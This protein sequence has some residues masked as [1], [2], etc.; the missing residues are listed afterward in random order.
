VSALEPVL[1]QRGGEWIGWPGL[2][3]RKRETIPSAKDEPY[4]VEAVPLTE[5]EANRYYHGFSNRTLWPLFHSLPARAVFDRRDW[6]AYEKVN[7]RFAQIAIGAARD[8]GLVW[9]HDYH[10]MRTPGFLRPHVPDAHMAFF[11]HIPFPPW[12]IFRLLPWSRELLQGVLACDLVGFHVDGYAQNFLD[13]VEKRLGARVDRSA[14]L[15]DYGGRVVRVGAFPLGIDFELFEKRA[16]DA[17]HAHRGRHNERMV[18][19][20]DRLDYTKGIPERIKAFE[21]LLER[22][23]K[24]RGKVVLFQLA[25]PS[26]S[27]VDDYRDLKREIDELVGRVNG[28][29]AT[30]TWSPIRYLYRS[31]PPDRLAAMYRDADVA[32]VTPL[33]DGMNLVAKE[34]IACQVDD[35]GV[36]VLSEMAGAAATMRE[37]IQVNPYD[38][39]ETSDAIHRALTMDE[40]ERR[41]RVASMRVREAR[42]NVYA[43]VSHFLEE[44]DSESAPLRPLTD[45]E[46]GAWLE[47]FLKQYH[48]SVFLDY[49]GT[50]TPLVEHPSKAK[51]PAEVRKYLKTLIARDDTDVAIVSGRAL[52]DV[53]KMVGI[54][55]VTYAGNHGLEVLAPD[56]PPFRHEDVDHYEG[57]ILELGTELEEVC[58]DGAWVE[59]KGHTLT[60]H[61]RPVKGDATRLV[62]RA[63]EIVREAGFQARAAHLAVEA[64]PPIGWDKG[65]AVL[66]VLRSRHGPAWTE[67]VRVIY[68]GDD[69]TDED[70]FQVL[71]G[72]AATF[73][74]GPADTISA[75]SRRLSDVAAVT[76]VLRWLAGR[77]RPS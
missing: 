57:R 70:A 8:A 3:L 33:R 72:M 75:A 31:V 68:I 25:V 49:D 39:D 54:E 2:A 52:D 19:G 38:L 27:Q 24:H 18:L 26:R 76:A 46:I 29:F 21:R 17:P 32:L 74:V 62:A 16:Q 5:S 65:R 37:A 64:R 51:L 63:R 43:W 45:A 11:L 69:Q 23:P 36:L 15:I 7:E 61:Y 28:R 6:A 66:H 9:I 42:D 48:L 77:K 34:F 55:Q 10:L 22:Y 40:A 67:N 14:G 41:S 73:R 53:R 71:A 58:T 59:L 56:L 35:P 30:A 47:P 44:A 60:W 13:C 12:D 4:A 50:L 20:V 1:R